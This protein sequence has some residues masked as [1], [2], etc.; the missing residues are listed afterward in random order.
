MTLGALLELAGEDS[1]DYLLGE[2][3]GIGIEG[4]QV[5]ISKK[6]SHGISGTYVDVILEESAHN[7]SRNYNDIK[8]LIEESAIS[9]G[10]KAIAKNI[11]LTIGEAEASVHGV[12]I[13]N[14]HFHEV[15]AID[16]IVDIVGTA[17]LL[18]RIKSDCIISGVVTEGC[19]F[20]E[21]AHGRMSVPVPATAEIFKNKGVVFRQSDVPT[22]LVTPTGAAIIGSLA[23]AYQSMPVA[24]IREI[25]YGFGSREIGYANV[26]RVF[27]LD[28]REEKDNAVIV[29][30]TNVD[31][32]TSE[33][34][35]YAME[36]LIGAGA[37]DVYFTPIFMKKNRPAYM[38]SVICDYSKLDGLSEI[39]FR[40][41]TSIG[42]RYYSAERKVL[43]R[44]FVSVKTEFGIISG[45]KVVTPGGSEYVYPEYEDMK[46]IAKA[47]DAQLREVKS[48]FEKAVVEMNCDR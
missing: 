23:E 38:L 5:K 18:D 8:A 37:R 45:K 44:E 32:S 36:C 33:A 28:C 46:A 48:A 24:D 31:D 20:I 43:E 30:E 2:L 10:A 15:G 16:S 35:G 4:Y 39:I 27:L 13:E 12:S 9:D 14:V 11:L 47:K 34:L 1:E 25:G 6:T 29:I 22:E 21:A 17:I 26:L 19:G 40:E 42:I 7:V 41:T 3:A